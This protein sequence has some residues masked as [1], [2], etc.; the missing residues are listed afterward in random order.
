MNILSNK[1]SEQTFT[2]L[3]IFMKVFY[4]TF[5]T[6]LFVNTFERSWAIYEIRCVMEN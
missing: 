2:N 1:K 5:L 4:C 6:E 3:R